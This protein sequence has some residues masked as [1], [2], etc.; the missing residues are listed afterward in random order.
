MKIL[1]K[2]LLKRQKK[3][4]GV[5]GLRSVL[6]LTVLNHFHSL[7]CSF[8]AWVANGCITGTTVMLFLIEVTGRFKKDWIMMRLIQEVE[9]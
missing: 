3:E 8:A 5:T 1:K 4:K 2:T 6:V 9:T 7:W